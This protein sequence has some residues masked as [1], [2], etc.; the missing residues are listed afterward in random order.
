M[1]NL[2]RQRTPFEWILLALALSAIGAVLL[3]LLIYSGSESGGD[4][5]LEI[6]VADSGRVING[7]PQVELTVTNTGG[8]G[9]ENV[10]IEVEM[11]GEIREVTIL[12]VPRDDKQR[13]AV[14]FPAGTSG[15]P[16]ASLHSYLQP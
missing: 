12:R 2:G 16:E 8:S 5:R 9:A 4:A 6:E 13:A 3:G 15:T 1:S 11:G 10:V 7:G 14:A